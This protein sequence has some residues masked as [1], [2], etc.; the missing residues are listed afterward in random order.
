MQDTK[1][2]SVYKAVEEYFQM[3]CEVKICPAHL[4]NKMFA[5]IRSLQKSSNNISQDY[6]TTKKGRKIS[7]CFILVI[8]RQFLVICFVYTSNRS[9]LLQL[10]ITLLENKEQTMLTG[11]QL[12]VLYGFINAYDVCTLTC[13]WSC[14]VLTF[15]FSLESWSWLF[16]SSCWSLVAAWPKSLVIFRS[17]SRNS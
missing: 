17:F 3:E 5:W 16:L 6:S 9:A 15:S 2:I 11:I 10:S 12:F 13:S 8:L 14:R 7:E 4:Q 1:N